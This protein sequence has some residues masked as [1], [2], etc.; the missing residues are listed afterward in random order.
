MKPRLRWNAC[1]IGYW[2]C[3]VIERGTIYQGVGGTATEAYAGMETLRG[4]PPVTSSEPER[5]AARSSAGASP[6]GL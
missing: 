2:T 5:R 4:G 3:H 1:G 6:I